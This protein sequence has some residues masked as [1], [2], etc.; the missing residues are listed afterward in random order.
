M[1]KKNI[2]QRLS[3]IV[4]GVGN[5]IQSNMQPE[6]PVYEFQ[7]RGNAPIYT[8]DSKE[9]RDRKL[10]QLRQDKLLAHQWK[11]ASYDSTS[12]KML[13]G[14]QV[15]VMYRD[16]DLMDAFPEIGAALDI[17]AEESCTR[18]T[19]GEMLVI[20]SKSERIKS[21]LEDLFIN[22]LDIPIT[23]PMIARNTYKYGNEFMLLNIDTENGITG[24]REL[25]V[26]EIQRIENGCG[27]GYGGGGAYSTSQIY[28]L[29]PDEVKF[30]WEGH[31]ESMP[32]KNWQVAHFRII[33]DSLFL[34]YGMSF[35]NK[36]RRHWRMLSM[37]EDAMLLYRLERSI[38]RRIYKVNVGLI[39]DADVP[40]YLQ[41]FMNNVKRAPI[42]DPQTG[43]ID[44]RKN[45]LDV[46]A[47]YVIPVRNGQD[48]TD[49]STLQSAQ[50]QTSMDDIE[51]MRD[52]IMAGLM[53]PKSYLN[54]QEAEGKGQN[55]SLM[56]I[57]F[58][59]RINSGQQSILMELNKIAIIHLYLLGFEDDLT[60][61]SLAL[62]NPSNQVELFELE[63]LQKRINIASSALAEQGGG[64]PLM[65]WHQVQKEIMGKTDSEIRDILNEIRLETA[66]ANEI[67]MTTQIIKKTGLF[68]KV[69][70]IYG[71]LGADYSQEGDGGP[72][73][74]G[75][76]GPVG[77]PMLGGMDAGFGDDLGDL[78]EPGA[79]D[80]GSMPGDM[81]S[82]PIDDE[83]MPDNLMEFKNASKMQFYNAYMKK[84]SDNI[85]KE[86]INSSM[87]ISN[88]KLNK[89]INKV[90][91]DIDNG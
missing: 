23:L 11:K 60:N 4:I 42:I 44:L 91:S 25:P 20:R 68:D 21:V 40:G 14:N 83:S 77:G 47:D 49:I 38:E 56:D 76:G 48:P 82:A 15:K 35:L 53:V 37:M 8:F 27:N 79:S 17:Y 26:H 46:S 75:P 30:I 57:R 19:K 31:G 12:L 62:N 7:K 64:I 28:N 2:F 16:A 54:F 45:F 24:W 86:D 84:L 6:V 78:G 66:L 29:K 88:D 32:Y 39:D 18:N 3:D 90:L 34:P 58:N 81:E 74:G 55:M 70:R 50:N 73:G 52:K 67:Q 59:R 5:G 72:E 71:E 22:R 65:S 43:Q 10:L 9:E 85:L 89:N 61:F 80:E 69:D 13:S 1:A 87:I 63:N 33:K 41:D 36:V 51:Y